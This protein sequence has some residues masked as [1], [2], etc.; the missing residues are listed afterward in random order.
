MRFKLGQKIINFLRGKNK[1]KPIKLAIP[2]VDSV[3]RCTYCGDVCIVGDRRTKIGSFVSI[4]THVFL[5]APEHPLGSLSTSPYF[6]M[7]FLKW[8]D[9]KHERSLSEPCE[10][11]NDVWIGDNVFIKGGI[12]IGHGAVVAAGAVVTKDV[13]PYAI[14]G[15]VPAKVIRYRFDEATIEAFLDLK[16]WDL[17]DELIKTLPFDDV[18]AC[19]LALKAMRANQAT[20]T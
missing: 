5:G 13:P 15:G 18:P 6:Y 9:I 7:G 19:L 14:V 12:K 4:A 3:G 17:P 16:W 8:K 11:G 10:V 1:N 2:Q 20:A